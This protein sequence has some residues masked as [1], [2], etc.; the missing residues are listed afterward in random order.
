M[1]TRKLA[2]AKQEHAPR[3]T[4]KSARRLNFTKAAVLRIAN[5]AR[6]AASACLQYNF[7]IID[8]SA[9]GAAAATKASRNRRF[10]GGPESSILVEATQSLVSME[11]EPRLSIYC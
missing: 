10:R 2:V 6:F 9:H 8:A 1:V 5:A 11:S 4:F 3:F 7:R